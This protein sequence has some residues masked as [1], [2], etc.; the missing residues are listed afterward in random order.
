[1]RAHRLFASGLAASIDSS[2]L[3]FTRDEVAQF[4]LKMHCQHDDQSVV[5]LTH[6]TEGWPIAVAWILRDA[7]EA[8]RPLRGAFERWMESCAHLLLEF[9]A[10]EH[11]RDRDAFNTFTAHLRERS[12]DALGDLEEGDALGFPVVRTRTSLRPYRIL[13]RLVRARLAA[14]KESESTIPRMTLHALGCF[15][16]E[17]GGR[18]LEFRRRRDRNILTYVALAP[19]GHATRKQLIDAFWPG[20]DRTVATQGLRTTLCRIRLAIADIVGAKSVDAYFS[21]TEDAIVN[22]DNVSLDVRRF[23][24][25]VRRGDLEYAR[26]ATQSAER[27]YT[28]T[29]R[30]Y[31]GALLASEAVEP[32]FFAHVRA[33]EDTYVET[34]VRRVQMYTAARDYP[35]ARTCACM[36]LERAK[37]EALRLR[38]IGLFDAIR[39]ATA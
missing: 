25:H 7:A 35:N 14:P 11:E 22:F 20:A 2:A 37:D 31:R 8:Y 24:D 1:M 4:A 32:C 18:P 16:C 17:I 26:G 5:Q 33:L 38:T 10:A 36:L 19:E 12:E 15:R 3:A 9:L 21:S 29:D 34:L 30:L 39:S 27:Y 13:S 28:T 23:L 6:D